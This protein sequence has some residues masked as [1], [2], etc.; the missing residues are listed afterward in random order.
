MD[1][2]TR[3][4]IEILVDAPLVPKI[5]A[6]LE[7]AEVHGHTVLPALS[8]SGRSGGWSEERV[9]TAESKRLLWAIATRDHAAAFVDVIG[10]LLESHGML[11]TLS[12]VQVVR[13]DR[14]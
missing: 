3:T 4:K 8:G 7:R 9:T 1:T 12:D 10:P 5:V 13:G 11:L 2:V 6:A 14:F